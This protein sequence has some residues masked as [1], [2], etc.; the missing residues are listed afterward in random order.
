MPIK[1]KAKHI[2][3][4]TRRLRSEG[5]LVGVSSE[6]GTDS[7]KTFQ[8]IVLAARRTS[9]AE[10][11]QAAH[12]AID[13]INTSLAASEE[14]LE[15][16]AHSNIEWSTLTSE[17]EKLDPN[18]TKSQVGKVKALT[19]EYEAKSRSNS[20]ENLTNMDFTKDLPIA[21]PTRAEGSLGAQ[22]ITRDTPNVNTFLEAQ[23]LAKEMLSPAKIHFLAR[24]A[25]AA[26]RD[27]ANETDIQ[28]ALLL[29]KHEGEADSAAGD[30]SEDEDQDEE[31]N[32]ALALRTAALQAKREAI[33]RQ[34]R[35]E[36]AMEAEMR[37]QM[38][39]N[40][41]DMLEPRGGVRSKHPTTLPH[42]RTKERA[43]SEDPSLLKRAEWE[44][45][46]PTEVA[47]REEW[48]AMADIPTFS[49]GS[50]H[51]SSGGYGIIPETTPTRGKTASKGTMEVESP[52]KS[53]EKTPHHPSQEGGLR[54]ACRLSR[55]G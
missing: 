37:K 20:V 4:S 24:S 16:L 41:E 25:E 40:M 17:L 14:A 13:S 52:P 43:E 31:F 29:E 28:R 9:A 55:G 35:K 19:E 42:E 27:L 30:T 23:Q 12:S 7:Y 53:K 51:G 44:L 15:E 5:A 11:C 50:M 10:E 36:A 2:E 46:S 38:D 33:E 8:Q 48:G 18:S 32:R 47:P 45:K 34:E 22:G 49:V 26:A 21:S 1:Y 39:S 6:A 3:P 54:T